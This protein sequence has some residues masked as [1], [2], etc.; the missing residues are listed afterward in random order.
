MHFCRVVCCLLLLLVLVLLLL[1]LLVLLLML[2][3]L[4]LLPCLLAPPAHLRVHDQ[5]VSRG[6]APVAIHVELILVLPSLHLEQRHPVARVAAAAAA[7]AQ[8]HV[9]L[10]PL[11]PAACKFVAEASQTA[12][13][14]SRT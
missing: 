5:R 3:Q 1:V 10:L 2:L 8:L 7:V 12:S 4:V 14:C 6:H 13:S 9:L 11:A